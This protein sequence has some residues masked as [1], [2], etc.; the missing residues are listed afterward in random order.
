MNDNWHDKVEWHYK[1]AFENYCRTHGVEKE[2]LSEEESDLIADFAGTHIGLFWM[3]IV[4]H[5]FEGEIHRDPE[6]Q[7]AI[8]MLESGKITGNDFIR[9]YCDNQIC[10]ENISDEILDF[11]RTSYDRYLHEYEKWVEHNRNGLLYQL[12]CTWELYSE[13][14]PMINRIYENYKNGK[15]RKSFWARLFHI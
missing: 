12:P 8:R 4:L 9:T 11:V 5:H 6:D 1:S 7:N 3:W 15:S 10:E 14:E 13:I 2:S